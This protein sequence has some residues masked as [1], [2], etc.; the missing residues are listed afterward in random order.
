MDLGIA[1]KW[2]LVCGASQ[3][4]GWGCAKALAAEGVNVLMVARRADQLARAATE[5]RVAV[6]DRAGAT[7]E[8]C[9]QDITTPQ[10]RAAVFAQRAAFDIL[11]TNAGGPPPGDFRAQDDAAWIAALQANMLTPIALMRALVDGMAER[12]FGRV[13]NITSSAVKAPIALLGLSNGARSGLTGFVADLARSDL[14]ARGVTL[15]NLLPGA[16]DTPR[17]RGLMQAQAQA[18]G[19]SADALAQDRCASIPARR[20]G[21]PEEFGAICAFLCSQQAAYLTGQN[22]LA[23]GGAYPG[24]F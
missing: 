7:V 15:N 8:I 16:F 4:L 10:G 13:V 21:T 18:S 1:G 12:G 6:A 19:R 3:G 11:V 14:A 17:L 2:A 9:A 23:D 22:I 5:I 24:T 20:F